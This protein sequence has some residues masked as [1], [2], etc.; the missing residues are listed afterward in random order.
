MQ[1][2]SASLGDLPSVRRRSWKTAED[3]V[4]AAADQGRHVERRADVA[5]T[6]PDGPPARIRPLSRLKGATPTRLARRRRE[7]CP[8]GAAPHSASRSEMASMTA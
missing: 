6:A 2:T 4:V 8:R 3:R 7:R 5:A 1:A